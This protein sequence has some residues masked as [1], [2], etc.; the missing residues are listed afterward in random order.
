MM[1]E[2]TTSEKNDELEQLCTYAEDMVLS[3]DD[4]GCYKMLCTFMGRYPD[5]PHPH[6]LMGILYEKEGRHTEAMKQFRA[7]LALD[8]TYRPASQNLDICG[9]FSSSGKCAFQETECTTN[10]TK[11]IHLFP[12]TGFIVRRSI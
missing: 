5:S 6:N 9:A 1:K 3:G 7:A 10:H 11:P 2:A 8:P 12:S 4:A